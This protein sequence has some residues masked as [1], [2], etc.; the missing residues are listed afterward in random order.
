MA[1]FTAKCPVSDRERAWIH[2][3]LSWFR[4][5]FGDEPLRAPVVLPTKE[6]FPPP[7]QG[8]DDDVRALVARLAGYMGVE[9]EV[10]VEFCDE[11]RHVRKLQRSM[12]GGLA[13]SSGAAGVY[14]R[15]D[16]EPV[17]TIDRAY[18]RDPVQLVAV[19][20]HELG[21]VRLLGENRITAGERDDH[22]PLT[23][24]LT[25]YLRL[26]VFAANAA[27]NFSTSSNPRC[28]A[29]SAQRLG[30]ITEQMF[31]YGLACWAMQ[32]GEPDPPW[33]RHLATNPQVYM[34]HGLRYLRQNPDP[35]VTG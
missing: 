16:G 30:Y 6:Y 28:T 20:A 15:D 9:A 35:V 13:S 2:E 27:F 33:S 1:L 23:D 34:K 7:Y 26:G 17:L 3:S 32:R 22:E 18:R 12:R 24:L 25:V 8:S 21:H 19:I 4:G 29:W 14:H 11:I 5:Q 10:T 31:G